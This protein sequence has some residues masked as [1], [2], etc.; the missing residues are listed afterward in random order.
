MHIGMLIVHHSIQVSARKVDDTPCGCSRK[1]FD[2][3]SIQQRQQLFDGFWKISHFDVQNAYLCGCVKVVDVH[4]RYTQSASSRRNYSRQYFVSNGSVSIQICK[5]AF[6]RIHATSNGRRSRALQAMQK[7]GGTPHS[8]QR[9]RHEPSN[10]Q[11][12][13]AIILARL[14]PIGNICHPI[15]L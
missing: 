9:G 10:K 7:E 12:T 11:G 6:L 2:V 15:Y 13:G 5:I 14:I 3:V 4:R 1:C 8:D